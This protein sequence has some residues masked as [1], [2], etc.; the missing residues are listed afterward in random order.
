MDTDGNL[1]WLK[2]QEKQHDEE[3]AAREAEGDDD[4]V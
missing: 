3:D 1:Y 4:E 2:Q